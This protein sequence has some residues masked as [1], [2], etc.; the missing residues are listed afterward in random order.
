MTNSD[1]S[2]KRKGPGLELQTTAYFQSL[3]YLVRRG[4]KLA[5][6]AGSAD[7]TDIDVLAIRFSIPL[8]EER[9]IADCKDRRKPKPYERVLW[10]RGLASFARA[11]RAVVVLP[12]V[13]WQAREF[14][15]QG[16]VEIVEARVMSNEAKHGDT[17]Y[18]TYGEADPVFD[19]LTARRKQRVQ[20]Q[21]STLVKE[22]AGEDLRLRQLLIVGHPLTNLNR[23]IRTLSSV[24]KRANQGS[25]EMRWLKLRTCYNAAVVAGVMLVRFACEVKWTPEE[26]WSEYARK[27]LTYGD[28]PP[29]K[30]RQLAKLALDT[31]F[32]EGLPSPEYT[33]EI[34]EVIRALVSQPAGASTVPQALDM[35]LFGQELGGIEDITELQTAA[36]HP[37]SAKLGNLVLS[38]LSYAAEVPVNL[39]EGNEEG[40]LP[41]SP[42]ESA[43]INKSQ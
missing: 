20:Q 43:T 8:A 19:Q 26:D 32:F 28:V 23:I 11:D 37:G 33:D 25:E 22:L 35:R 24:G 4:V 10:T 12:R 27:K 39:W 7:V 40:L 38:A 36:L 1:K 31:S 6:A 15:A 14:G 42:V 2:K 21:D 30:A 29:Q 18:W 34:V 17:P 3:G 41:S 9:L 16:N 13:P 5:I